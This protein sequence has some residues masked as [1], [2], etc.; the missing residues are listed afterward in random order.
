MVIINIR[1]KSHSLTREPEHGLLEQS[2]STI[3]S[4]QPL[5]WSNY[6]IKNAP[7][8]SNSTN[9]VQRSSSGTPISLGVV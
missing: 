8:G 4:H 9:T 3:I 7:K 6:V 1:I 5:Y 2:V